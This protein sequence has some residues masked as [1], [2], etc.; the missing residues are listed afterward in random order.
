MRFEI[1][2]QT[3]DVILVC[4]LGSAVVHYPHLISEQLNYFTLNIALK[5]TDGSAKIICLGLQA[6]ISRYAQ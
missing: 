4:E 2:P 3:V 1:M 6:L 5:Q